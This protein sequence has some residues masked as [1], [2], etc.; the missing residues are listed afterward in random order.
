MATTLLGIMKYI[1]GHN[2][3]MKQA[4]AMKLGHH[5]E[6]WQSYYSLCQS[7]CHDNPDDVTS[8]INAENAIK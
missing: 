3:G 1:F 4:M 5:V 8:W 7:S 6:L 2:F